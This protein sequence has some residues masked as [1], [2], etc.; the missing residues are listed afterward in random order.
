M[1]T[2]MTVIAVLMLSSCIRLD[3]LMFSPDTSIKTYQLDAFEGRQE[4]DLPEA[5]ALPDSLIEVFTLESDLE[6]D[7]AEIYAVY[8][9]N[10]NLISTDTVILYLH[11]NAGHL[12][13]YWNRIKLLANTG[14]KNRFGVL[15]IDYRGYGL[16]G[17]TPSEDG[18][19]ADTDA[20][21][22][23]LKE[24]GLTSDRLVIYGFSMGS[25]PATELTANPRTLQPS[26][27]ML[28]APFASDE[29]M[30]QDAS[31]LSLPGSYISNLEINNADEIAK[32]D[33]PFFWIHGVDD[34]YLSI[35]THGE[36]VFKN[37]QGIYSE[38]HRI[39]GANHGDVPFIMGFEEYIDAVTQFVER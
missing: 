2:L 5:Y 36:V 20:A 26:K 19:Y 33:E 7:K 32:V 13:F 16:S 29:V 30:L 14:A 27:L 6:G 4:I 1:R 3:S 31:G 38:A 39:E 10:Q 17:G 34:D 21:M 22:K 12:D 23:W 35:E 11:G 8:V 24:K 28:E 15:A 18:L 25:A 9:G 37:Y